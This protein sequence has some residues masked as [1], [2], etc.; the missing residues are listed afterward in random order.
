MKKN[1]AKTK[2]DLPKF[3]KITYLCLGII[4]LALF[5]FYSPKTEYDTYYKI[6]RTPA[7]KILINKISN[8]VLPNKKSFRCG[9]KSVDRLEYAKCWSSYYNKPIYLWPNYKIKGADFANVNLFAPVPKTVDMNWDLRDKFQKGLSIIL[10]GVSLIFLW[11]LR[12]KVV[13]SL[14]A[15]YKRI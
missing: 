12:D 1:D 9:T 6:Y 5:F 7:N 3:F 4:I 2:Y 10:F 14:L 15:F 8:T 13:N 11:R